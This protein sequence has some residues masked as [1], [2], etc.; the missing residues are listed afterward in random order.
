MAGFVDDLMKEITEFLKGEVSDHLEQAK[1]DARAFLESA[2]NKLQ[3]WLDQLTSGQIT[4]DEFEFLVKSQRD[5]AEM[6]ALTQIGL[7]KA[8]I[9]RIV[10]GIIQ[11]VIDAGFKAI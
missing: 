1:A 10:N 9:D 6:N 8:R 3:K 5:L 11:T 7:A 4:T 2:K